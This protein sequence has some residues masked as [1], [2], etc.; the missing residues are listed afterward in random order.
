M[1][2]TQARR[3]LLGLEAAGGPSANGSPAKCA[4][5]KPRETNKLASTWALLWGA[6]RPEG[7]MGLSPMAS[8]YRTHEQPT[9]ADEFSRPGERLWPCPGY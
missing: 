3:R 8:R 9:P 6:G 1:Y 5:V 2:Q 7:D 4:P